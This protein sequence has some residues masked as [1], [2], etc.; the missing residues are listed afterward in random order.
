M[1]EIRVRFND[2]KAINAM[3]CLDK[4]KK[5]VMSWKKDKGGK[6]ESISI[7][8]DYYLIGFDSASDINDSMCL[9]AFY[10]QRDNEI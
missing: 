4:D 2:R 8:E 9:M 3:E 1:K 5:A 10:L 6:W 7:P